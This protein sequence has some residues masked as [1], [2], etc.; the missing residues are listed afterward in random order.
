MRRLSKEALY[1][2]YIQGRWLESHGYRF[3]A[4]RLI[5]ELVAG[6]YGEKTKRGFK[7][8]AVEP[9]PAE[10]NNMIRDTGLLAARNFRSEYLGITSA[11]ERL[12]MVLDCLF[13]GILLAI[14]AAYL[15]YVGFFAY[16]AK[17]YSK[18]GSGT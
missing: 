7:F 9:N 3:N 8:D 18:F 13:V 4:D 2:E 11:R 5:D 10:L 6:G 12:Q 17:I 14:P 15:H 16:L 1:Q